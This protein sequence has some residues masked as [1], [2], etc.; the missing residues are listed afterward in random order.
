MHFPDDGVMIPVIELNGI[1]NPARPGKR[2]PDGPSMG[3][4]EIHYKRS[5]FATRLFGDR[6]YTSGHA[7]MRKEADGVWRVGLTKFAVR[8]LGEIVELGFEVKPGEPVKTG[9][10]L[11]WTEGFK[12]VSDLYAPMSGTFEGTNPEVERDPGLILKD[13]HGRGWLYAVRGE[14]DPGCLDV[15]AYIGV[16]DATID[17]MLGQRHES[18][19]H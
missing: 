3:S 19:G 7:W 2:G 8:M 15:N 6:L 18:A 13:V 12:A 16:L 5:R 4:E 1:R 14:P 9:Q 10:P 17:K 11:G